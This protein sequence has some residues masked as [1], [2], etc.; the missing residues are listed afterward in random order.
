MDLVTIRVNP[1]SGDSSAVLYGSSDAESTQIGTVEKGEVLKVLDRGNKFTEVQITPRGANTP[2]GGSSDEA[3]CIA[4]PYTYMYKDNKR[5]TILGRV[6]NGTW[7]NI[8]EINDDN[9]MYKVK[10]MTINGIYSGYME[11]RYLFRK[12]LDIP[13]EDE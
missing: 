10:G 2:K 11:A 12:C 13:S 1:A 5:K 4:N 9:G 7:I 8:L 6:N 3:I